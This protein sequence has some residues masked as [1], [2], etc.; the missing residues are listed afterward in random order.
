MPSADTAPDLQP[1][2]ER[3]RPEV[4]S[5][6]AYIV[7]HP[8]NIQVKLN[9]NE[10]PFDLPRE[11]KEE[12]AAELL[13]TP[14]NR[15]P[16]EQPYELRDALAA[17]LGVEPEMLLLGNGSNELTY[18]FGL[19]L[20]EPGTPVVMP[21][22]MFSLYEKVARLHGAALTSVPPTPD[23]HFDVDALLRAIESVEPALVVV[24]TPNNPT[25]LTLPLADIERLLAAS[26][27]FVVVDEAYYEFLEGP[28]AQ[29]L[30]DDYPNLIILRTFSKAAGLAGVRL[31]Y[32]LGHTALIQEIFKARLPFMIDRV[33]EAAGL[34]LLRH[35][36]LVRDRIR[37]MKQGMKTLS[38][39]LRAIEGVDVV[40]SQAN[41]MI[42]R[43]PLE[44]DVVMRRLAEDGVLIR[45]MGGYADLQGYLR[46][47]AGTPEE[48]NQFL[49]A[50]KRALATKGG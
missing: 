5:D 11:M 35:P 21:T 36:D 22:P 26:P 27:G 25:G 18:T 8:P 29:S 48:N 7:S 28:T 39:G 10:S 30:L 47:N 16:N 4:R 37:L 50:L 45:N 31:G 24:T 23:F 44:P 9:Q 49:T 38:A 17:H 14:L 6:H 2:I 33:A 3:I 15:Y 12:L 13:N 34:M 32:M 46:V 19:T 20:L 41:F 40:P 43:P 42:F 1:L